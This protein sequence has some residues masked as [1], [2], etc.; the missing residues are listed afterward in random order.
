VKLTLLLIRPLSE[1]YGSIRR[2]GGKTANCPVRRN[3][4][5]ILVVKKIYAGNIFNY[6]INKQ[7]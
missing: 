1:A 4:L 3:R 5:K 7:R 2:G 6:R